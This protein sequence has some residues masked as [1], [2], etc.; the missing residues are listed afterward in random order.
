MRCLEKASTVLPNAENLP[1][2]TLVSHKKLQ[3]LPLRSRVL[4]WSGGASQRHVAVAFAS[5]TKAAGFASAQKNSPGAL[6][7]HFTAHKNLYSAHGPLRT[8]PSCL[9]SLYFQL[10][11]SI[12]I[13]ILPFQ[14][15]QF[16]LHVLC[17]AITSRLLHSKLLL[18]LSKWV[19]NL[20]Q[21]MDGGLTPL[22]P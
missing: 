9:L 6:H 5:T 13:L 8:K 18:S 15:V 19:E 17:F 10:T 3:K 2:I 7:A 4:C 21:R 11:C 20:P 16:A 1:R 14:V 22:T 12:R